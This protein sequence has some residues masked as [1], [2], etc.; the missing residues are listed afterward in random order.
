MHALCYKL[1]NEVFKHP[2]AFNFKPGELNTRSES[3]K[4]HKL[5]KKKEL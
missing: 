3:G 4:K 5:K 2:R 1:F